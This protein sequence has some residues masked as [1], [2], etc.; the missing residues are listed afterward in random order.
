M[1]GR[2][3]VFRR[4][5]ADGLLAGDTL[6]LADE[7]PEGEPLLREV[8][9]NGRRCGEL[10]SLLAA[11]EYCRARVAELPPALRLLEEGDAAYPVR[12]SERLKG[13]AA[14]LD[15]AGD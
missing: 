10:P 12:V 5:G 1:A 13:L 2:K 3:Q 6:A 7:A 9:R 14:A 8:M 15:A 4:R 11:R